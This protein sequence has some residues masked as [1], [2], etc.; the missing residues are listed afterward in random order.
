MTHT[1]SFLADLIMSAACFVSNKDEAKR[2]LATANRYWMHSTD[3]YRDEV[4]DCAMLIME[5]IVHRLEGRIQL[6]LCREREAE[7]ILRRYDV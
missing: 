5:G 1:H 3:R 2:L 7:R 6:A 4:L